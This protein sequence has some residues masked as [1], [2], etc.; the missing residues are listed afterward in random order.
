[1]KKN[2]IIIVISIIIICFANINKIFS[3]DT[4][5]NNKLDYDIFNLSLPPIDT[6]FTYLE[7]NS[8]ISFH[9][10]R[11]LEQE[12]IIKTKKNE[13]LNY[14]K[15]TSSYQYGYL[16]SEYLATGI[17]IPTFYQTSQNAQN[18]YH[19]GVSL[20]IPIGDLVNHS[21]N[22]KKEKFRLNQIKAEK[23]ISL[24]EQKFI[25]I[26]LYNKANEQLNALKDISEAR[27]YAKLKTKIS[28]N[29]FI[30]RII[31]IDELTKA[32]KAESDVNSIYERS[33]SELLISLM[34][35]EVICNYK[36][37]II[38]HL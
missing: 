4:L 14:L 33:K 29:D 1:M 28:Q 7:K 9:D 8:N 37:S 30:N 38:K 21:N 10:N 15:F 32:K 22:V 18:L 11:L 3:Q 19:I 13:W 12:L 5:E 26:E 27:N 6:L 36:F 24:Y 35:I 2:K 23:E 16:G 20:I 31:D 34:K 25:V 17:Q